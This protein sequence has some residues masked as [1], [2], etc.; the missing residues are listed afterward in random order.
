MVLIPSRLVKSNFFSRS[1]SF[2]LLRYGL[3]GVS[4]VSRLLNKLGVEIKGKWT[5]K[6]TERIFQNRVRRW[7]WQ[8]DM[9]ISSCRRR[10]ELSATSPFDCRHLVATDNCTVFRDSKCM[11]KSYPTLVSW[12][13]YYVLHMHSFDTTFRAWVNRQDNAIVVRCSLARRVPLSVFPFLVSP[14]NLGFRQF[15]PAYIQLLYLNISGQ[16]LWISETLLH[17]WSNSYSFIG[18]EFQAQC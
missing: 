1:R 9:L 12:A 17:T 13:F 8:Q 15:Q 6:P 16:S 11:P 2:L 10:I 18:S 7:L 3:C 4:T 14:S 5:W